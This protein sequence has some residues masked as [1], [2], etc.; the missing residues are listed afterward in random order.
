MERDDFLIPKQ[1]VA[2]S[3]PVDRSLFSSN[4]LYSAL[5]NNGF[6]AISPPQVS[7]ATFR[8]AVEVAICIQAT[9]IFRSTFAF[10]LL[11]LDFFLP[12]C[13]P[14]RTYSLVRVVGYSACSAGR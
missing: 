3:N 11:N 5:Q 8:S 4:W 10:R 13:L 6:P 14:I 1:N 2:G 12:T 7:L 9:S